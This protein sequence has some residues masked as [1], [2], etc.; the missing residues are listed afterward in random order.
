[1]TKGAT[2][3]CVSS[4]PRARATV[5]VRLCRVCGACAGARGGL[6]RPRGWCARGASAACR[7]SLASCR[8]SA[9]RRRGPPDAHVASWRVFV[10]DSARGVA[11]RGR[12]VCRVSDKSNRESVDRESRNRTGRTKCTALRSALFTVC[13][14]LYT[15]QGFSSRHN[16]QSTYAERRDTE[17]RKREFSS[18][19]SCKSVFYYKALLPLRT[20]T[21]QCAYHAW[22]L[23]RIAIMLHGEHTGI[24]IRCLD[25]SL[26][27]PLAVDA[28]STAV[29]SRGLQHP[30]RCALAGRVWPHVGH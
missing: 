24:K 27:W 16:A 29:V 13:T 14:L 6:L 26:C 4:E 5:R 17:N 19:P 23:D 1:M 2:E 10:G 22:S 7:V 3:R 12:G 20:R 11:R 28:A 21:C 15:G 25:A 18:F 9:V 30:S 8:V